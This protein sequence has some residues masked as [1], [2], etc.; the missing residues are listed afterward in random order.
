MDTDTLWQI[1]AVAGFAAALLAFGALCG[2]ALYRN[3][4]RDEAIA[5]DEDEAWWDTTVRRAPDVEPT[6]PDLAVVAG[7]TPLPR[8]E[9]GATRVGGWLPP[10]DDPRVTRYPDQPAAQ[11]KKRSCR[12]C[13]CTDDDACEGG[14]SWVEPDLCST[15]GGPADRDETDVKTAS[16]KTLKV[17]VPR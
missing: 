1:L 6:P 5:R 3:G 16:V 8:R 17:T 12:E 14:C 9:P 7:V 11:V 4:R 15:C 13:G 10:L 2:W